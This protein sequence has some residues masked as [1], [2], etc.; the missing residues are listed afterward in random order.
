MKISFTKTLPARSRYFIAAFA[1]VAAL[2]GTALTGAHESWA[3]LGAIGAILSLKTHYERS[4]DPRMPV[5][6]TV[7]VGV[8][9]VVAIGVF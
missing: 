2:A 1:A 5:V 3:L 7:L 9:P 6:L 4:S 8:V